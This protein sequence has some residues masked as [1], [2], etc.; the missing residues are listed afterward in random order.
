MEKTVMTS[1]TTQTTV[2]FLSP[3]LLPGFAVSQPCGEYRVDHD[4]ESIEGLSRLAWR[5]IGTFIHLPAI[6]PQSSTQQMVPIAAAEF[7]A[8]LEKDHERS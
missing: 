6:T 4:E 5:R 1:R 7:E 2:R 3:F 8:L